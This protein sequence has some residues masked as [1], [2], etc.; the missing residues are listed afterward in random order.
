MPMEIYY[1]LQSPRT[2]NGYSTPCLEFL[3]LTYDFDPFSEVRQFYRHMRTPKS[4]G[5]ELRIEAL[6]SFP[7]SAEGT[8]QLRCE[9]GTRREMGGK[10]QKFLREGCSS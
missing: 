2:L 8:P 9:V 5:G 3:P 7:Q 6:Y 4:Q 1:L 10:S